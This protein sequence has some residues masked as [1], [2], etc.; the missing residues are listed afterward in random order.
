M[1][2]DGCGEAPL[3]RSLL[4]RPAQF[5]RVDPCLSVVH[6]TPATTQKNMETW[7]SFRHSPPRL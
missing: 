7:L 3:M 1:D 4:F 5:I 2:T 6:H